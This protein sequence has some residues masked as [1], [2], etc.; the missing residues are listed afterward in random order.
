MMA[1]GWHWPVGSGVGTWRRRMGAAG[2]CSAGILLLWPAL[3]AA[4]ALPSAEA[5]EVPAPLPQRIDEA[6]NRGV[7]SAV[8][9]RCSDETFLRR[10]SLDFRGFTATA[11]E[12]RAF[13][14]DTAPDKR[15]RLIDALI[16]DPHH[17]RHLATVL[18]VMLMERRAERH[19]KPAEWRAW[20][21][22][23]VTARTPWD[24]MVKSL[25]VADGAEG[26][27]EPDKPDKPASPPRGAARWLLDR[28]AEPNALTRD[29][30]RL[31]LGTDLSCAQ[32]HDHPRIADYWQRDY[33]GLLAF[34]SRTY[35]FQPDPMKPALVGER[36]EG[37]ASFVSVFTKIGGHP[38]PCLPGGEVIAEA[39][40]SPADVWLVAPN[41]KDKSVRPVPRH[42][43][44]ALLADQLTN[45]R[46]FALNAANRFWATLMGRGVVEPVDLRHSANPPAADDLLEILADGLITLRYDISAFWRE[47][48]QSRAYQ[49]PYDTPSRPA[50][51]ALDE[52]AL[53]TAAET[54]TATEH[55]TRR[56]ESAAREAW[57]PLQRTVQSIEAE[58][59]AAAKAVADARPP[60]D[61]ARTALEAA[62]SALVQKAESLAVIESAATRCA[63]AA[64]IVAD[65]PE[66]ARAAE[67]LQARLA[68]AR[69]EQETLTTDVAA[70]EA[71]HSAKTGVLTAAEQK[72]A[73]VAQ[74]SAEA[75]AAAANA[76]KQVAESAESARAARADARRASR[77]ATRA[78]ALAEVRDAS[79]R[80]DDA[81]RQ[82][83]QDDRS[84]QAVAAAATGA[85][86]AGTRLPEDSELAA[87]IAQV[88]SRRTATAAAA[89]ASRQAAA[90]AALAFAAATESLVPQ[91]TEGFA[92]ASL[93]PLTPEQLCWSLLRATGTLDQ[94]LTQATR[95]WDEKNP[96]PTDPAAAVEPARAAARSSGVQAL[97]EEKVRPHED[98]FVRLFGNGAGSPQTDFFATSDQALYFENAGV[99]R[100]WTQ[101]GGGNL[102][103]RL[104]AI[105][106]PTSIA[107]ELY[108]AVLNRPASDEESAA[109]VSHL[110]SRPP[111]Q[112]SAALS[113]ALWALLTSAEFRFKH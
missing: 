60:A 97:L 29:V 28:E 16:A 94:L 91:W 31:F 50:D 53:K 106:E 2:M 43:R 70:K 30:S 52:P 102:A 79:R 78:R 39:A 21:R 80:L 104:T 105:T 25:L 100:G 87:V 17:A 45:S 96:A 101:P 84:A 44:R 61:A 18:D 107:R 90:E 15:A 20:L 81:T 36:A 93:T 10:A 54:A 3:W 40:V 49:A 55:E 19:V 32:C 63:E 62:R 6:L 88:E 85:Q 68:T 67:L 22:Q 47:V 73:A 86:A 38:R 98:Q 72:A 14:A 41:D 89:E 82:R 59:A 57:E 48:A 110:S 76:W 1:I 95:E 9:D 27:S 4:S 65:A 83:E 75:T 51:V 108:L 12:V 69:K 23:A 77:D 99:L 103:E 46:G 64:A 92:L 26:A 35:L 112:K 56:R 71:D 5:S 33:Q 42:S 58:S 74:R 109:I 37:E 111:D 7:A 24:Q 13:L 113:D 8:T 66:L 11:D 34:F